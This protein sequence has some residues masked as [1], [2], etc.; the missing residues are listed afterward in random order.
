[1]KIVRP[2]FWRYYT[3]QLITTCCECAFFSY[4]KTIAS[5]VGEDPPGDSQE[6]CMWPTDR[7]VKKGAKSFE[8]N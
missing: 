5:C 8:K 7:F 2:D 4:C 1:M 6:E 3:G